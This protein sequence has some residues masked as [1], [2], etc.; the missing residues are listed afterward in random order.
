LQVYLTVCAAKR[1]GE[2][3]SVYLRPCSSKYNETWSSFFASKAAVFR[4]PFPV[5]V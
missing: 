2:N 1:H 5:M 4:A 3:N